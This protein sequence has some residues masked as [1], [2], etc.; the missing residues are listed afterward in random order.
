[1]NLSPQDLEKITD[2]TLSHYNELAEE[3]W[4]GTAIT[5]STRTSR[6]LV[7]RH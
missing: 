5:T 2:L 4:D 1:M 6:A 3:F 7:Q